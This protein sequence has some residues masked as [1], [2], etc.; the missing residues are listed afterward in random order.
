VNGRPVRLAPR[1]PGASPTI[2]SAASIG[3]NES[4]GA[5]NQSGSRSRQV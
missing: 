3:P 4:T 2:S 5:L 1:S